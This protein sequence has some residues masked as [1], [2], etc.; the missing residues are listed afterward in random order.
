MPAIST[1]RDRPLDLMGAIQSAGDLVND[2]GG[3]M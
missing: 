2:L 3:S 1:A